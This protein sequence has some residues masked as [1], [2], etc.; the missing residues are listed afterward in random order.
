MIIPLGDQDPDDL[1]DDEILRA[2]AD[3]NVD[4]AY[5]RICLEALR[6]RRHGE[7]LE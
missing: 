7:P 6:G 3:N 2:Y 1:T 4:E 5:A